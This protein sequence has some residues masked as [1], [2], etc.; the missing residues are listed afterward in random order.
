MSMSRFRPTI[1][2][3]L[4]EDW[5]AKEE[6][7]LLAPDGQANV[8]ASSEP[9]DSEIDSERYASAQSELLKKEF[10]GF[11]EFAFEPTEVF[12]GKHGYIRRFE[13]LPPDNVAV[14]QIQIYYAEAGR[15]YAAT[16][17]T[18]SDKFE[19][20]EPA[21]RGILDGLLCDEQGAGRR[22]TGVSS[23][24]ERPLDLQS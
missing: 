22:V 8:I 11:H 2:A 15:G 6:I 16:T 24:T 18:P 17:T 13:W 14:T 12:G 4:P 23:A 21:L 1:S 9:L 5:F 20:Y 7:T 10:P 3:P 19:E